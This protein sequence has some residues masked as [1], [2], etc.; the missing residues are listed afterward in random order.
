MKYVFNCLKYVFNHYVLFVLIVV[1]MG[2]IIFMQQYI[3]NKH[4]LSESAEQSYQLANLASEIRLGNSEVA[5]KMC[6]D[7]IARNFKRLDEMNVIANMN[8]RF[9]SFIVPVCDFMRAEGEHGFE[10]HRFGLESNV[11]YSN[12][13]CNSVICRFMKKENDKKQPESREK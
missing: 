1:A 12:S 9:K 11:Q 8:E 6:R 10:T 4:I 13:K 7:E 3:W 2:Y 5:V